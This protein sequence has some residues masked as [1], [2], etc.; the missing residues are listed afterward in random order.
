MTGKMP[1]TTYKKAERLISAVE[2]VSGLP[3]RVSWDDQLD[4]GAVLHLSEVNFSKQLRISVKPNRPDIPYLIGLQCML[5]KRFYQQGETKHLSSS[6]DCI[7]K[8]INDFLSLGYDESTAKKCADTCIKGLG[9]QLR[10]IAPQILFTTQMYRDY[11]ELRDSQL[12]HFLYEKEDWIRSL[13]LDKT[14]FPEWILHTHQA[15]NGTTALAADYLFERTDFFEPFKEQGLEAICVG[16][17]GDITNSKPNTTDTQLVTAW[18][19]RLNL[20]DCFKWIT[21]K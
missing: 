18:L 14:Q 5:A 16:L 12:T 21:T 2:K 7:D 3:V 19:N 20:T 6:V 8:A 11:P 17:F 15:I 13:E 1:D 9:Q 10:S 4:V